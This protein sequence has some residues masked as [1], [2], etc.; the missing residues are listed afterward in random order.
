MQVDICKTRISIKEN[1]KF[2]ALRPCAIQG[3]FFRQGVWKVGLHLGAEQ[4]IVTFSLP[5]GQP[6]QFA[7][8]CLLS[9][10]TDIKQHLYLLPFIFF[11]EI[12]STFRYPV[13]TEIVGFWQLNYG[14]SVLFPPFSSPCLQR[15]ATVKLI[16]NSGPMPFGDSRWLG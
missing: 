1:G 11:P 16:S 7:N 8:L 13:I 6:L 15:G 4:V 14:N 10:I 3:H 2:K 5:R 9:G 12:L